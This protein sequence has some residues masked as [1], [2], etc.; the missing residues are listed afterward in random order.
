MK[1]LPLTKEMFNVFDNEGKVHYYKSKREY[2][3][4]N[5]AVFSNVDISSREF[6]LGESSLLFK[7]NLLLNGFNGEEFSITW[8]SNK[9]IIYVNRLLNNNFDIIKEY[10]SIFLIIDYTNNSI[11]YNV[12]GE[13]IIISKDFTVSGVL[14]FVLTDRFGSSYNILKLK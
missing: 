13:D 8:R 5:S 12:N 14:S 2:L 3:G 9:T 6:R 10:E 11:R 7:G 1:N 4:R